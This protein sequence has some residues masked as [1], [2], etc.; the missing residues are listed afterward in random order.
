MKC[1]HGQTW[2]HLNYNVSVC[3]KWV[4]F[5]GGFCLFVFGG[6]RF[7]LIIELAIR[8]FKTTAVRFYLTDNL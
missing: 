8:L 2:E 6:E 7:A 1:P 4:L 5:F 3:G